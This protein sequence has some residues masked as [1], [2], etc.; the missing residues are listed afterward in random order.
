[1][2]K[3]EIGSFK[4]QK[5]CEYLCAQGLKIIDRNF[6]CRSG[7]IDIIAGDREYLVFAEVKFRSSDAFGGAAYAI[8]RVKQKRIRETAAAFIRERGTCG[9]RFF[10]FD[11]ILITGETIEYIKNAWQ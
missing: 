6:S 7:E 8:S 2:N 3:R 5:A 4:E 11:A 10:R 1:M 9:Y